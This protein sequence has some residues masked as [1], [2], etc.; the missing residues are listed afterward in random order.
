MNLT[1]QDEIAVY[2]EGVR[3]A[4]AGVPA[5]IRDELLE[6]LPEHLAEVLAE[7]GGSL[8]ER[9][10]PPEAYAAELIASAGIPAAGA[11]PAGGRSRLADQAAETAARHRARLRGFL[12]RADVRIGPLLGYPKASD[13]LV[14]L[15]PAWWV[16]RGYLAAMAAAVMLHDHSSPLGL[17]PR[18]GGDDFIALLLLTLGILGSVWLGRRTAPAG[19]WRRRAI[20]FGSAFLVLFAV[21]GFFE[22]DSAAQ[23]DSYQ[24]VSYNGGP[25]GGLDDVYVYDGQGRLLTGVHLYDQ[26]GSPILLGDG[27]CY[28]ETGIALFESRAMGYPQC[29]DTPPFNERGPGAAADPRA[30]PDASP[31]T[32]DASPAASAASPATPGASSAAPAPSSAAPTVG[33]SAEASVPAAPR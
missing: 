29:P 9:L 27:Y 7:G 3:Q 33:P 10:G 18:V 1:A 22:V 2:V 15:R 31:A 20:R 5:G 26:N 8:T 21:I 32:P 17:L 19:R 24:E 30:T 23:Q 14:L 25:F 4:L 12:D 13:F 16:L 11:R 28:D 6:D